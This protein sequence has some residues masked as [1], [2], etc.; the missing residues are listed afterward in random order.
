[1]AVGANERSEALIESMDVDVCEATSEE[2]CE[3][4]GIHIISCKGWF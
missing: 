1:M 4:H 3:F 2:D